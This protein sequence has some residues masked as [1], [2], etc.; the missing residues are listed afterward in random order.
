MIYD[1]GT[2]FSFSPLNDP[3]LVIL[4]FEFRFLVHPNF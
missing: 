1:T 4:P 3:I 2:V